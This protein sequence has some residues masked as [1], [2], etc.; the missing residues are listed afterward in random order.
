MLDGAE[1][2]LREEGYGALTSRCIADRIGVKQRL[3]Y[4]YFKTMDDLIVE[5]FRR[6]AVRE[7]DRLKRAV[8]SKKPVQGIWEIFAETA[9]TRL[10]SEFMAL[11]N[12]STALRKE[13][14]EFIRKTRNMQISALTKASGGKGA[15]PAV[16]SAAAIIFATSAALLLHREA[17]L[18]IRTGH[19]ETLAVIKNFVA[20]HSRRQRT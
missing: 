9:D 14:K 1:D 11:A 7:M 13:V 2:V 5:T 10:V 17:A 18:G 6:L 16:P 8:E 12:R 19:A 4:Y 20:M 3:V 15:D